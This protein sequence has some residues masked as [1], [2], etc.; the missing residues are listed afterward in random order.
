[1]PAGK[2]ARYY[3]MPTRWPA[4]RGEAPGPGNLGKGRKENQAW[5]RGQGLGAPGAA[6]RLTRPCPRQQ[7]WAERQLCHIP[8]IRQTA[9]FGCLAEP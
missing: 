9:C 5:W 8:V 1:M 6:H 7:A 3:G 4:T 2:A